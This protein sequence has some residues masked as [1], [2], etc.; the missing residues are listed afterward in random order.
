MVISTYQAALLHAKAYRI[1]RNDIAD[2]LKP[3]GISLPEWSTLETVA[4][5]S[6]IRSTELALEL[7]VEI[8]MVTT[9][10]HQLDEKKL[11]L[12]SENTDDKRSRMIVLTPEGQALVD[13]IEEKFKTALPHYFEGLSLEDIHGHLR[14]LRRI[15]EKHVVK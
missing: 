3:F 9:L 7:G 10:L 8:P 2:M 5:N 11:I 15:I 12:R 13:G 4:K 14:V 1:L 6:T